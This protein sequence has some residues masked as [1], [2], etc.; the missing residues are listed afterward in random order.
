MTAHLA[1][2]PVLE[3]ERLILRAPRAEDFDAFAPFV[4]SERSRFIGGGADKDRG[5]AWRVLAVLSGH[6]HLHGWG[7][8][9]AE[10]KASGAPLGSMGPWYPA[11]WPE[12]ELGWTIWDPRA[13]GTGIA[14]EAVERVRRHAFGDLGWTTAVSYIDPQNSRSIALAERLGCRLDETAARPH[15]DEPGLVYRHPAP[16]TLA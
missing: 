6:W 9:V 11:G 10:S 4:M 13:E 12:R 3:T 14:F 16:E 5:F 7:T 2:T 15:P 1:D 8:F